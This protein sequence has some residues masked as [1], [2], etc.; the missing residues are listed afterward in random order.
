MCN[1]RVAEDELTIELTRDQAMVLS[2]WLGRMIGTARFDGT[3][4][5][6]PAVWSPL[7]RIAGRLEHSLP[8]LFAPDAPERLTE[9]RGRLRQ[10]LTGPGL[11]PFG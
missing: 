9:A 2:D 5:G 6:D 11:R 7:F 1:R 8:E 3:V 10:T 4:N